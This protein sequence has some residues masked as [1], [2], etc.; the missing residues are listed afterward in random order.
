MRQRRG[1]SVENYRQLYVSYLTTDA[2]VAAQAEIEEELSSK[3]PHYST[4]TRRVLRGVWSDLERERMLRQMEL[5][6]PEEGE[7]S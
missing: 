3:N 4:E 5:W 6:E 1:F 7:E 2:I